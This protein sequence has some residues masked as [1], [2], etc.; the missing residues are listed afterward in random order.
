MARDEDQ[1][2]GLLPLLPLVLVLVAARACASHEGSGRR[3]VSV[4]LGTAPL[5]VPTGERMWCDLCVLCAN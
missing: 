3:R 1:A 4:L 5:L 2:R